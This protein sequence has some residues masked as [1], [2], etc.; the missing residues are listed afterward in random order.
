MRGFLLASF[1]ILTNILFINVVSATSWYYSGWPHRQTILITNN[2]STPEDYQVRL[3]FNASMIDYSKANDDGSDLR[4]TYYN[5]DVGGEEEVSY[6][7]EKWNESGD[8]V[9]WIKAPKI[10]GIYYVY[11]GNG[12]VVSESNIHTTFIFGD[13]FEDG[14]ID[15]SLWK[16]GG[17]ISVGTWVENNGILSQTS[18]T[19]TLKAMLVNLSESSWIASVKMRPDSWGNDYR[20]G[21][22]GRETIGEGYS[23]PY[24]N[25]Y[26][27][28]YGHV[29]TI[30]YT[31]RSKVRWLNEHYKSLSEAWGPEVDPGFTFSI[32]TWYNI[33]TAFINS[34]SMKGGVW[35]V[36][37]PMLDWLVSNNNMHNL[38]NKNTGMYGGYTS[39]FSFDD[40]R[41]RK[42]SS[43]EPTY[44]IGEIE[45]PEPPELI[46]TDMEN[47]FE[48][49]I[50]DLLRQFFTGQYIDVLLTAWVSNDNS[51][52][53]VKSNFSAY[54]GILT[55]DAVQMNRVGEGRYSKEYTVAS[56]LEIVQHA[57]GFLVSYLTS[58]T[59]LSSLGFEPDVI[60]DYVNI[61]D[62]LE[63]FHP[64]VVGERLPTILEGLPNRFLERAVMMRSAC[65]VDMLVIDPEGRRTG[66][67]YE[68]GE[69]AGMVNEIDKS[70]YTGRG[71]EP[72]FVVI[73]D[74]MEGVYRIEIYGNETGVYNLSVMSVDNGSVFYGKNYTN[75][76][77]N[78]GEI[79][80][81]EEPISDVEA[82]EA[83]IGYD[84]VFEELVVEGK[85][86]FDKDVSVTYEEGCSRHLFGRCV[87]RG[88]DYTLTDN[89]GNQLIFTMRHNKIN[90]SNKFRGFS[91]I[92]A[93]LLK[94]NYTTKYGSDEVSYKRNWLSYNIRK[95]L[96]EV[97]GFS[98]NIYMKGKGFL[99]AHYESKKNETWVIGN[100][101]NGPGMSVLE[102]LHVYNVITDLEESVKIDS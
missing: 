78:Q 50:H 96:G 38:T 18:T 16:A 69:F 53:S 42:Y 70:A 97:K 23:G 72:E 79:Q 59:E 93:R 76:S 1:F 52:D 15:N 64:Y 92:Y 19:E 7:V 75:I 11:Y 66:A 34:T 86:N 74:P 77:I 99:R 10:E 41:V 30:S 2:L 91:L 73:F 98:Q 27:G 83:V 5:P 102:G 44:T 56:A 37:T 40:F 39:T 25:E 65:P 22:A 80:I 95:R 21:L 33:E 24:S 67:L 17:P 6:W 31:N 62:V 47:L 100:F 13:D 14:I 57:I 51:I 61:K 55:L 48:G 26:I 35:K 54:P 101:E 81:Y 32:G 68:N 87:E 29:F 85:D 84:P 4:F 82:P 8:G 94:A 9:V 28:F 89:A 58:G 88:R 3:V 63:I 12:E 90:R 46:D 71:T 60:W 20:G 36:G 43:Q 45:S 49:S